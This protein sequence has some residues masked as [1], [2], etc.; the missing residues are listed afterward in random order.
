VIETPLSHPWLILCIGVIIVLAIL[1][2]N[3]LRRLGLPPLVGFIALG[4]LLNLAHIE[5]G[6]LDAG[7]RKIFRLLAEIG[8]ITLLFRIGLESNIIGLLRQ[9]R[10]ASFVW[11]SGVT[12]SAA[13]GYGAAALMGLALLPCLF[14]AIALTA[15]SV[16]VTV[17]IWHDAGALDSSLGELLVDVAELD[18][19]SGIILMALL[20][21]VAPVLQSGRNLEVLP[22]ALKTGALL[23]LKLALFGL[24][25][26][27]F[28]HYLEGRITAFFRRFATPPAPMLVVGGLGFVMASLA[29]VL[30]F[31][32]AIGAF[33]AGLVFS[34][35][36]DAVKIDASFDS[37]YDLFSP[38]FFVG[39][40]LHLDPRGLSG[41][42]GLG[43]VLLMAAVVGKLLGHG[44]PVLP[45][46][47]WSGA[48][49]VGVSMAPRAE[50]AL[51]IMEQG[52]KLGKWAVP[53]EVYAAMV[54]VSAA[55]CMFTPFVVRSLLNRWPEAAEA[56]PA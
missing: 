19:I 37:L 18:D 49:L 7:A 46:L 35:D 40:G 15:T 54:L 23:L 8:L 41:A 48:L 44:L 10:R 20:F 39:L 9:L 21:A 2:K 52:L 33:F 12:V 3:G 6:F 14:V 32:M 51:I 25:C 34:R 29:G 55:T 16:G 31:S 1:V 26:Y 53:S 30:G 47:G 27:G 4:F 22:I 17:G 43:L 11:L 5:F 50:I 42:L 38:F 13:L 24:A 28:A 56:G 36:P 45:S